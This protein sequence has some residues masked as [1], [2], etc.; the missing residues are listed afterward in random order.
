MVEGVSHTPGA[1]GGDDPGLGIWW[2][3]T[4]RLSTA[5]EDT[6]SVCLQFVC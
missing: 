6:K 3:F 1:P 2:V 4:E 5:V